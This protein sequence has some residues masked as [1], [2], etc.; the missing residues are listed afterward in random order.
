M[1]SVWYV[2]CVC[3]C[4][5]VCVCG[6]N[7]FAQ[8][9]SMMLLGSCYGADCSTNHIPVVGIRCSKFVVE[10]CHHLALDVWLEKEGM[11]QSRTHEEYD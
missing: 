6:Q 3:V 8:G 10:G 2:L 4:V 11:T 7:Q 1:V 9:Q 5:C